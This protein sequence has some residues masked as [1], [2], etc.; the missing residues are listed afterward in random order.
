MAEIQDNIVAGAAGISVEG[1]SVNSPGNM[2]EVAV[3]GNEVN[4]SRDEGIR[5]TGGFDAAL[6]NVVFGEIRA[7]EVEGSP[8]SSG[9]LLGG[10]TSCLTKHRRGG[11]H[12][13][14]C[15]RCD[16]RDQS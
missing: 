4:A 10:R 15:R 11:G 3:V 16:D 13:Q 14:C 6:D 1:G 12:G 7:N 2:V 9:I 5:L 8:T